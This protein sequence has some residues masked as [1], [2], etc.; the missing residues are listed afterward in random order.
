MLWQSIHLSGKVAN[1]SEMSIA[2][3]LQ[4]GSGS[5]L[6]AEKVGRGVCLT[7]CISCLFSILIGFTFHPYV[8]NQ[9]MGP[10]EVLQPF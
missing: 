1:L 8:F 2:S 4:F 9:I 7:H 3:I 5:M 10:G 6:G